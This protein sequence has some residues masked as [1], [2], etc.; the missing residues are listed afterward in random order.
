MG[1]LWMAGMMKTGPNDISVIIW[2]I[3]NFF[4]INFYVL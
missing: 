1:G 2:A 3:I 4:M